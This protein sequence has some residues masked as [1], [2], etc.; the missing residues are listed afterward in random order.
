MF[1]L[2]LNCPSPDFLNCKKYANDR[3]AWASWLHHFVS[4]CDCAVAD[5]SSYEIGRKNTGDQ[6][7]RKTKND[8]MEVRSE[9]DRICSPPVSLS[10][11]T[12][13]LCTAVPVSRTTAFTK[14]QK[15][16]NFNVFVNSFLPFK[17]VPTWGMYCKS[18]IFIEISTYQ[19]ENLFVKH[20][21]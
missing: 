3:K 11:V 4:S 15:R 16:L 5:V 2:V 18:Y 14:Q 10:P 9:S 6:Q 13:T 12:L 8:Y 17:F 19:Q 7:L 20:K 1:I 21:A